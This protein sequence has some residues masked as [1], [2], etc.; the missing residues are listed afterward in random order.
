MAGNGFCESCGAALHEGAQFCG[1]CGHVA[2]GAPTAAASSPLPPTP[3]AAASAPVVAVA[4]GGAG[5]SP[6][7]LIPTLIGAVVV[8]LIGIGVV[9][10]AGGGDGDKTS[11]SGAGQ[12]AVVLE[13]INAR[14]PHPFTDQATTGTETNVQTASLPATVPA[15]AATGGQVDGSAPGLY[16]GSG[17]AKVCDREQLIAFLETN[18]AK[19]A[20]WAGVIGIAPSQIRTY[21]M[22]LTPVLLTRDT[23]VLNHGFV[24]G[25]ATPKNS[26]L[27]AG[28]AVLVDKYG[29]P[30]VKCNCGNPL[31][32]PTL[33][34]AARVVGT[35]WPGFSTTNILVVVVNVVVQNFTLVDINTGALINRPVATDGSQDG[36]VLID[37]LC[38]LYPDDPQCA[39]LEPAPVEP[40]PTLAPQPGHTTPPTAYPDY[41]NLYPEQDGCGGY[42]SNDTPPDYTSNPCDPS[43]PYYD[44]Y[45]P[46]CAVG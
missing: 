33:T 5:G 22:G 32:E 46:Q 8:A 9:L 15:R 1:K 17:N 40:P 2:T 3:P 10:V 37:T 13:P 45:D 31:A 38:D 7:W 23:L 42:P 26:V 19:A 24:N 28:T 41:C 30:R 11:K 43:D 29:I 20:A 34:K 27:Q 35:P 44:P 21:V 4:S 36:A 6:A 14:V 16:G 18:P 12:G 39:P 25:R